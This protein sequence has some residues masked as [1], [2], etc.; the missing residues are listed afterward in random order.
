MHGRDPLLPLTSLITPRGRYLGTNKGKILIQNLRNLYQVVAQRLK[1]TRERKRPQPIDPK[2]TRFQPGQMVLLKDHAPD[3]WDPRFK[4][5]WRIVSVTPT[6]ARLVD[7]TGKER[8]AHQT[9]LKLIN[10]TEHVAN[11]V[12]DYKKF[13]RASSQAVNPEAFKDITKLHDSLAGLT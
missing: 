4:G 3:V 6:T 5:P 2:L 7:N 8:K 9:D 1:E 10:P 12:P 11:Q 13:G